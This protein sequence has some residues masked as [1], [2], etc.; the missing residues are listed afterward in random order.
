M[1]TDSINMVM[2]IGLPQLVE[3]IAD[4]VVHP[5]V[6]DLALR[7]GLALVYSNVLP[8]SGAWDM[9]ASCGAMHHVV[10][11]TCG[12]WDMLA[13]THSCAQTCA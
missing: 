10:R 4:L 12:A 9:L 6:H 7:L 3:G 8:V 1:A 11:G 13:S 5:E 2:M